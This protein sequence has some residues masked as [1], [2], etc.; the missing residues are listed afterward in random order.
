MMKRGCAMDFIHFHPFSTS[1]EAKASKIPDMVKILSEYSFGS[2]LYLVPF[3]PFQMGVMGEITKYELVIFR[4]F[5]LQVAERLA[6]QEGLGALVT[7]DSLG[8]VASQT[9]ENLSVVEEA[10]GITLFRPLIGFD[11]E[12]IVA[13]A[14]EIR[15]FDTSVRDYK[16][17]CSILAR[18]PETKAHLGSVKRAEEKLDLEAM[19]KQ[20]LE[21]LEVMRIGQSGLS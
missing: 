14:R 4:R 21:G 19:F 20:T 3:L 7:G 6:R 17:C 2:N 13:L 10:A 9:M 11:K 16:D 8:Q 1:E 18:H 12:E 15:T 5:M